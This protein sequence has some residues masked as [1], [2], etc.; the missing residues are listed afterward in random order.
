MIYLDIDLEFLNKKALQIRRTVL[1]TAIWGGKGHIPPAFSW[2]DIAAA[3]F[4]G[5]ILQVDSQNPKWKD[6]DRFILSKGHACLSLYAALSDLGFFSTEELK[7]FAGNGSMLPG[8]PDAE[9]PGVEVCSGSLGHGLSVGA[10]MATSAKLNGLS[11]FTYVVLGDGECHEGS[12]WEAAMYSGHQKLGRLIAIVDRNMLGATDFTENYAS[13]GSIA[14]RFEA[15]GWDS[16]EV[17]GHN[18]QELMQALS[19]SRERS[20]DAKPLCVIA[21]T[22]KGKGVDFMENSKFWHHQMPKGEQINLAWKQLG[23]TPAND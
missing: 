19:Q 7:F 14:A 3:L 4:Y 13:L 18:F 6:R 10:G 11:W 1:Q 21:H 22:T 8:H 5:N 16:V 20:L 15:F 2:A 23:G 12:I 17:D 9:I